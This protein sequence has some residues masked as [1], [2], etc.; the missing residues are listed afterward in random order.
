MVAHG[1]ENRARD[2]INFIVARGL[3]IGQ[4]VLDLESG[5]YHSVMLSCRAILQIQSLNDSGLVWGLCVCVPGLLTLNLS[6]R[7][8][9]SRQKIP[10]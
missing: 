6:L 8:R 9:T 3:R 5:V 2:E 4:G 7:N 10:N 1:T